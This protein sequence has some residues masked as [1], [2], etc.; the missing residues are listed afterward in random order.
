MRNIPVFLTGAV[1]GLLTVTAARY[2]GALA[3]ALTAVVLAA[4][5]CGQGS[6]IRRRRK[7]PPAA[8]CLHPGAIPVESVLDASVVIAQ[9]CPDCGEQLDAG[10]TPG[11][12][13]RSAEDPAPAA[14]AAG[15]QAS[16]VRGRP[17]ACSYCCGRAGVHGAE[18]IALYQEE[19]AAVMAAARPAACVACGR[20]RA[21]YHGMCTGCYQE[22]RIR[23]VTINNI[24]HRGEANR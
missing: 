4:L 21:R 9:L 3:G 1:L 13:P 23:A 17:C 24:I 18:A 12:P 11:P 5:I 14:A 20:Y 7:T 10:F 15:G 19:T 2:A 6:R 8:G 22:R 16:A